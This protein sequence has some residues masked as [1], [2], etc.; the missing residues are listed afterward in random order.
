MNII[1]KLMDW[2]H[3]DP[4]KALGKE[5]DF[6]GSGVDMRNA[7]EIPKPEY[8]PDV[9]NKLLAAADALREIARMTANK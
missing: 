7:A 6:A 5:K 3:S 8:H 2:L 1:K 9:V 4:V